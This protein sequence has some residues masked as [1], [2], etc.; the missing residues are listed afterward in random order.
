M[1]KTK[2]QTVCFDLKKPK[3]WVVGPGRPLSM[4]VEIL[5]LQG[6]SVKQE[7]PEGFGNQESSSFKGGEDVNC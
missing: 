4:P 1:A 5:A 3:L 6:H 7:P 2:P